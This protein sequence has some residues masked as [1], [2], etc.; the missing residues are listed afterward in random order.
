ML[1][2]DVFI[3]AEVRAAEVCGLAFFNLAMLSDAT[4]CRGG[5]MTCHSILN[6]KPHVYDNSSLTTRCKIVHGVG[7]FEATTHPRPFKHWK[8]RR[9]EVSGK[10]T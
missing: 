1:F 5:A 3:A 8:Q 10:E 4:G 6:L 7:L 9:E 2:W